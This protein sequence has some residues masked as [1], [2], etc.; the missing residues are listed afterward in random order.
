MSGPTKKILT[1]DEIQI[2]NLDFITLKNIV[3]FTQK[4]S[5]FTN[6]II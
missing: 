2:P 4:T 1:D 6:I 5:N 3:L